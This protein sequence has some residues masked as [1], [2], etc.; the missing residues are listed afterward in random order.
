MAEQRDV[1]FTLP[2]RRNVDRDHLQA[3]VEVLPEASG[4]HFLIE[5]EIGGR[6]H[7]HVYLHRGMAAHRQHLFFLQKT[8]QLHLQPRGNL[9]NL[10]Q[11]NRAAVGHF[12]QAFFI[13]IGPGKGA[14]FIAVEFAFDQLFRDGGAV[15][16]NE[17]TLVADAI[18][19][20]RPGEEFLSGAGLAG[21]QYRGAVVEHLADHL[22]HRLHV[23][24]V[25]DDPFEG[26][27]AVKFLFEQVILAAQF[28]HQPGILNGDGRLVGK[29]AEEF[30]A[31][32]I[33][34]G[35]LRLAV[36]VDHPDQLPLQKQR[37]AGDG[38][39]LVEH[40]AGRFFK[41]FIAGSVIG[42]DRLLFRDDRLHC[43]RGD[44]RDIADLIRID[45][46]YSRRLERPP[47][48]RAQ[49]NKSP[50]RRQLLQG[51]IQNPLQQRLAVLDRVDLPA[52]LQQ[53]L[54]VL[55]RYVQTFSQSLIEGN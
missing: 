40:H 50:L 25:P 13:G 8:Q 12:N 3:V 53:G 47:I 54:Q 1:G 22:K 52:D 33:Q 23:G 9:G 31:L 21:D 16:G 14:F 4:L 5:I 44:F 38:G 49:Q 11:E 39:D 35:G 41:L 46:L 17:G 28:C 20:D 32:L 7:P 42:Q 45:I 51:D 24:A 37:N 30:Q 6:D 48:F 36:D 29:G 55:L 27:D 26:V 10:V 34:P 43:G 19:V 15:D 18:V 2:Q